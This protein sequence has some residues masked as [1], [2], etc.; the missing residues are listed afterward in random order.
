MKISLPIFEDAKILVVGDL[1]L[2]RYWHGG[3]SRISPEAP[4]QVVNVGQIE[5][6]PGGAGNVALNLSTLGSQVTL[7]GLT[8]QDEAAEIL[9][10]RLT[11][12]GVQCDFEKCECIPTITK[13]RVI[14]RQ[15]QLIRLDF[16]EKMDQHG[17]EN[18]K[19][20]MLEHLSD[21]DA[22]V[23]SDYAKGTLEYVSELIDVANEKNIPVLVDPKGDAF[24]R[25][26]GATIVTPN[27]HEFEAVVGCCSDEE[28][29]VAKGTK[30]L[31]EHGW[32]ALLITRG[33]SG[34][35][36]IREGMPELHLPAVA[37]E[38]FDVT[39]AGDTVIATLAGAIAAGSKLEDAVAIS[40]IAAGI[41]VLKL[42]T[43]AVTSHEI[44]RRLR[45]SGDSG[46]GVM[47]E[48]QLK[49]VVDEA[50]AH[51][52]KVVM[53][54]GCF[55]ILHAGH[56]SYLQKAKALG[57][58]LIVAVNDDQSVRRLKGEGRPINPLDRR[59][60]VLAALGSVDWVVSFSEDTPQELIASILP[61]VL[62]KGGDYQVEE[63]A[64]GKEVTSAGG[65][66]KVLNFIDGVST[67]NII[68]SIHQN[69][70]VAEE[71]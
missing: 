3:S 19:R 4:V 66:V 17:G 24:D 7:V 18:I 31:K 15:Q 34:M 64:G 37:R 14:S 70:G 56:V 23:L 59:M 10:T 57:N 67:T 46:T 51:G 25:Y 42:G 65:E 68:D 21:C 35:T 50:K 71:S 26:R 47:S 43:A 5:E 28:E 13:L 60:S 52:E 54:N 62:V 44:R 12:A 1:M 38:V 20:R 22:I 2:D 45:V 36:L 8:G 33:E 40:N 11:A 53:T 32:Q 9:Q 58:K 41:V 63:I 27:L 16:E 29:L 30:M 6:R 55:D 49:I 61:D 48:Q 39:G 69:N